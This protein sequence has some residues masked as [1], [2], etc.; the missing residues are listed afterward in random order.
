MDTFVVTTSA[1]Q[2]AS[3]DKAVAKS[4]QHNGVCG[5]GPQEQPF[6]REN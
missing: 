4:V 1:N 3:F 5:R 2:K 6:L